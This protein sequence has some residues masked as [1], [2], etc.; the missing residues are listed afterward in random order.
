MKQMLTTKSLD[1]M[2]P[3]TTKRYEV[4]DRKVNGLQVRVSTTGAKVFYK[5]VRPNGSRRRVKIGLYPVVSLADTRRHAMEIARDV[6][7][8]LDNIVAGGTPTRANRALA[9]TRPL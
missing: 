9:V 2:P 6:V 5:M 3:A 8:V 4:R 1:A 7:A